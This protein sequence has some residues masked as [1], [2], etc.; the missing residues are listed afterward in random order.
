[1]IVAMWSGKCIQ[2]FCEACPTEAAEAV[3]VTQIR[4]NYLRGFFY[5]KNNGE[6]WRRHT[7][8]EYQTDEEEFSSC[9]RDSGDSIS[10]DTEVDT[11]ALLNMDQDE[12]AAINRKSSFQKNCLC[13]VQ[14]RRLEKN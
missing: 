9:A 10:S 8:S 14:L 7:R 12:G 6:L 5:F 1:M 13:R 4:R 11:D 3:Q 2:A